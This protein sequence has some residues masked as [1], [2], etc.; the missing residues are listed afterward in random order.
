MVN[1]MQNV[2]L[3]NININRSLKTSIDVEISHGWQGKR[4]RCLAKVKMK[5]RA[6]TRS[7]QILAF[8]AVFVCR[9]NSV[10]LLV[11]DEFLLPWSMMFWSFTMMVCW[12]MDISR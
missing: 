8:K 11:V 9:I 5:V 2:S 6:L 4:L 10:I 12:A 7:E 1:P 3:L